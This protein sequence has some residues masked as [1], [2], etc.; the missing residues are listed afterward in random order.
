M[1]HSSVLGLALVREA[2][3][4]EFLT[5]N[6][7]VI[8]SV[9]LVV[10]VISIRVNILI[11]NMTSTAGREGLKIWLVMQTLPSPPRWQSTERLNLHR[12]WKSTYNKY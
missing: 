4:G 6:I 8:N 1:G 12:G 10:L 7:A 9:P 2:V 3:R 5:S 11:A